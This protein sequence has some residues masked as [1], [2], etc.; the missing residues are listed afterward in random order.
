MFRASITNFMTA[1]LAVLMA[2]L[3]VAVLILAIRD[4]NSFQV[5]VRIDRLTDVDRA[6]FDAQV[7][8]RAQV[9]INSMALL[10][11]E[12]PRP[13]IEASARETARSLAAALAAF[14][15]VNVAGHEALESEIQSDWNRM[16][17]LTQETLD[18]AKLPR[19]GRSLIAL[20]SWRSSIHELIT[21]LSLA[22]ASV[23]GIVRIGDGR[24][25]E[26][27]EVRETAWVI[28]DRYGLQCSG[29]RPS[30]EANAPLAA[31]V[32]DTWIGDRAV[33]LA[34]WT[35][36]DMLLSDPTSSR[37]LQQ[38]A[39]AARRGTQA[40]QAQIDRVVE[41]LG[42]APRA[43]VSGSQ[44]T[45]LCDA[46][47]AAVLAVA[48][49]AQQEASDR[50]EK[51]R[52]ESFRILLIAGADL[53]AV[54]AF[55]IAALVTVRRRFARPMRHLTASI[56]RFS[57][58]DYSTPV[59]GIESPDE[60]GSMA[61]AL[62]TLRTGALE[63]ERLQLAMNRFTSDA[64]HQMR[65]PLA[66]LRSHIA[67]LESQ[68]GA[69]HPAHASLVDV[70]EAADRLQRLLIQ[71]L[72]LARAEAAQ[73]EEAESSDLAE[74]V[75]DTAREYAQQAKGAGV[76]LQFESD[77]LPCSTR[78]SRIVIHEILSNLI[79]NAIRYNR[80]G[81]RVIVRLRQERDA[82]IVLEVEDNGPG[83]PESEWPQALT[84]F[85]RMPRD[86][87]RSGSGLG[88]AIVESLVSSLGG[89]LTRAPESDSGG[90]T[91][92]IVIPRAS[93]AGRHAP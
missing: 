51:L 90:L 6:L 7:A 86:Q 18:Q 71:L 76:E 40:A 82:A 44:W 49:Q 66:I 93:Q 33:Y 89:R 56:D 31:S 22:S 67:V 91:V 38:L 58:R 74:I 83:I 64:S 20:D 72:K 4:W 84:R 46:P 26:L 62:E 21:T 23:H 28:R 39:T 13:V 79:D 61:N 43:P 25:G 77:G 29:L 60:L 73:A 14:R 45:S 65:T 17:A 24:I 48:R 34:A 85:Y 53:T 57:R 35:N 70:R 63:A 11:R 1:A 75:A 50:A 8:A 87:A 52:G 80:P 42:R 37:E 92:R 5:A 59:P 81:G 30:V 10:E 2:G 9:P 15:S 41:Q 78:L 36:L 19:S 54:V 32:R 88:L 47:F 27:V 69:A 12:D 55:G 3:F 16:S 68:I